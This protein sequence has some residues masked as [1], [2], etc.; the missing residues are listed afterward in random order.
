MD[1]LN[2]EWNLYN[3]EQ[4]KAGGKNLPLFETGLVVSLR[5]TARPCILAGRFA[6]LHC[7]PMHPNIKA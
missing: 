2:F 3:C 1:A 4:K 6:S 7:S 5:C